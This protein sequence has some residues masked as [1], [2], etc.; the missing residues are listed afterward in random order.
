MADT[1]LMTGVVV[2]SLTD[3]TNRANMTIKATARKAEVK[4][5]SPGSVIFQFLHKVDDF[6]CENQ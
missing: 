3:S 4:M 1:L 2:V 6:A 5:A